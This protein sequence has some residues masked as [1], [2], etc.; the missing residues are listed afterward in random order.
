MIVVLSWNQVRCAHVWLWLARVHEIAQSR[1]AVHRRYRRE[2]LND[3][4]LKYVA[5][6]SWMDQGPRLAKE[7]LEERGIVL[8]VEP[9]LPA[10]HLDGAALLGRGGTPVIGLTI[11]QDRL[12]NFWFTLMHE[13]VHAWKH[14]S[15]DNRRAIADESI[16][17]S[18]Q[19]EVFEREA[20]ERAAE[21]FIPQSVWRRSEAFRKPSAKSIKALADE[22]QISPSIVA[23]RVRREQRN[24]SLFSGLVG[25]RQVRR[26]FPDVKWGLEQVAAGLD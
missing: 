5:R 11:R 21:I 19:T 14:L 20:S 16:E 1:T 12:D 26:Q 23:G 18:G 6:L 7:F 22:L 15:N 4:A 9:H 10:T 25:V 24:F 2:T 17:T 3:D 8:V 13:L